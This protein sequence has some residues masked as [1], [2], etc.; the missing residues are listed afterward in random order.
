MCEKISCSEE[1]ERNGNRCDSP[2]AQLAMHFV[3]PSDEA[4]DDEME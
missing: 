2:N 3:I 4:D 1:K